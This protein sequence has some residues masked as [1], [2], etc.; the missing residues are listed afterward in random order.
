MVLFTIDI[1][2]LKNLHDEEFR[3]SKNEESEAFERVILLD[4]S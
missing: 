2:A 3:L 4:M 1:T